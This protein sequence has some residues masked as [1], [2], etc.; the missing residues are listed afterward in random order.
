MLLIFII[1]GYLIGNK[2]NRIQQNEIP[3]PIQSYKIQNSPYNM[4]IITS[5]IISILIFIIENIQMNNPTMKIINIILIEIIIITMTVYNF[6]NILK[7]E[8]YQWSWKMIIFGG[9]ITIFKIILNKIINKIILGKT[10]MEE[11][12]YFNRILNFTTNSTMKNSLLFNGIL[13]FIM[14][15]S[16]CYII[17]LIVSIVLIKIR[18]KN[19]EDDLLPY[20]HE[21]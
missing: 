18:S 6:V 5:L 10:G 13:E 4:I 3:R 9:N 17:S 20:L 7:K 12:F 16:F 21:N 11:I 1:I 2:L 8:D 14:Y 19:D 15:G